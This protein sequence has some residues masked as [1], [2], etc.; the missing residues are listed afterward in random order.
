MAS[1]KQGAL[2]YLQKQTLVNKKM[3]HILDHGSTYAQTIKY[4]E[5]N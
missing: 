5:V 1:V 4:Q 3:N 2:K